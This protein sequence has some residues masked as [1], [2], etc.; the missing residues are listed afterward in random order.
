MNLY[1]YVE[2]N[3]LVRTDPTGMAQ[4]DFF[5]YDIDISSG[6]S[7][8]GSA[9]FRSDKE[10]CDDLDKNQANYNIPSSVQ[11]VTICCDGRKVGCAIESNMS[12]SDPVASSIVAGCIIQH[13][14]SHFPGTDDCF[15]RP[16]GT[17]IPLFTR[18]PYKSKWETKAREECVAYSKQWVCLLATKHL[19]HNDDTCLKQVE[20]EIEEVTK[21]LDH[22]CS[23]W[24]SYN[25]DW[26]GANA[27]TLK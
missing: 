15:S 3:P 17:C 6:F 27:S 16:W 10:C 26:A 20:D 1:G 22:Y 21:L 23:K 5:D 4:Y 14:K 19:C 24:K 7:H 9:Q 25:P 18:E 2:N 12:A 11:G 13:E 8:L